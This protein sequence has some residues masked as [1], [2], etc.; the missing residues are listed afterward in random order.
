M[1]AYASDKAEDAVV[2]VNRST[3]GHCTGFIIAP[4]TVVTA[5]HCL[6]I[7]RTR[8]WI[9]PRS[10]HVL[11]GYDRGKYRQ[12]L[13][14]T[15]YRVAKTF[16][17]RL[18]PGKD[19]GVGDWALLTLHAPYDGRPLPLAKRRPPNGLK[20][21]LAGFA[22]TKRHRLTRHAVCRVTKVGKVRFLH[23]CPA[24]TGL[25]GAPLFAWS[26]GAR[27]AF[28][29]HAA[30]SKSRGLAVL[31]TMIRRDAAYTPYSQ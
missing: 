11:V 19:A 17:P 22:S 1:P 28:G 29:V 13:R 26:N 24:V 18:K 21:S 25:S 3:G 20:L 27:V 5:A 9:Q 16:R 14:V 4:K 8:H 31:S 12:H 10:L 15:A 30:S 6:W 23:S 7:Q 2:R